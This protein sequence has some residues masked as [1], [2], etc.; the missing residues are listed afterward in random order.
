MIAI[1][2]T[3]GIGSGKSTV[4]RMLSD[5]GAERIDAD[6]LARAAVEP[7]SKGFREVKARFG[8]GLIRPDG[9]LDRAGLARIVFDDEAARR[10][11]NAIVHPEVSRLMAEQLALHVGTTAVVVL[12]IPLLVDGGGRDRYPVAAVLVVDSPIELAVERLVSH[13]HM[14]EDDARRRIAAQAPREHRLRQAD[15][16]IL[17]TGTLEELRLMADRAWEWMEAMRDRP[18]D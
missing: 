3:G 11:L 10:D 4:A 7:G 8:D 17:N 6:E 13:R 12:E 1:A 18:A 16:I 2:L 9:S 14:D 15:Y 5:H